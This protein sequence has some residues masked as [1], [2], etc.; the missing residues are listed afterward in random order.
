MNCL[1]ARPQGNLR[2]RKGLRYAMLHQMR[3]GGKNL[4]S[5]YPENVNIA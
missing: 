3:M 1:N 2:V 4:K 5:G